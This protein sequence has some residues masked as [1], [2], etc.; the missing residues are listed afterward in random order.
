MRED[1][2]LALRA[3]RVRDRMGKKTPRDVRGNAFADE[4]IFL[5]IQRA[6]RSGRVVRFAR[7]R[8]PGVL[9]V[10]DVKTPPKNDN[11]TIIAEEGEEVSIYVPMWKHTGDK[12]KTLA[13]IMAMQDDGP[14]A[15]TLNLNIGPD[16]IQMA[17]QAKEKRGVGF[18]RFLRDRMTKRLK[19]ALKPFGLDTPDFFFW[20]EA[21]RAGREHAHGVIVIP[22]HPEPTKLMRTIRSALK[23]AA[24][25]WNPAEHENQ[26]RLKQMHDPAGWAGYVTKWRN[27]T[28]LRIQN[29]STVAAS[30]GVR[31]RASAWYMEARA[32]GAPISQPAGLL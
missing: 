10:G 1:I 29:E 7:R 31:S 6:L 24:G 12:L 2:R 25:R 9:V 8:T 14:R 5:E 20:V 15:R 18:A 11:K 28:R 27:L 19:K 16:V 23:S 21:D 17:R 3:Q 13:W 26:V 22:D 32:S 30:G 4:V